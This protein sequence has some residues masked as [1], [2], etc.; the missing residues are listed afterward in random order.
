MFRTSTAR[1]SAGLAGAVAVGAL[2]AG[3]VLLVGS[4]PRDV[5]VAQGDYAVPF[6]SLQDWVTYSDAVVI[7][8]AASDTELEPTQDELEAGEG[9]IVRQVTVEIKS[10]VWESP[11][12]RDLPATMLINN[13][14]WVFHG[15]KRTPIMMEG[16]IPLEVGHD[17][18][19]PIFR[20]PALGD[21]WGTLGPLIPIDDSVVGSGAKATSEAYQSSSIAELVPVGTS[22]EGV[23]SLMAGTNPDPRAAVFPDLRYSELYQAIQRSQRPPDDPEEA[24]GP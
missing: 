20:D 11:D 17:Y 4:L 12:K 5:I 2:V 13:G 16:S 9:L 3:A 23:A 1:I 18:A 6:D 22:P 24:K 7:F 14:G 19:A 15:D 8:H 21:E 10:I